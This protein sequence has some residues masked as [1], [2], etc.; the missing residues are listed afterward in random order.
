LQAEGLVLGDHDCNNFLE[1]CCDREV[2]LQ[3]CASLGGNVC[4]YDQTCSGSIT[5]ALDGACCIGGL[6]QTAGIEGCS[7]DGDCPTGEI[8]TDGECVSESGGGCSSDSDCASGQKC[9]NGSC[10]DESGNLWVWILL[11]AVL[12]ILVVIGIMFRDK[13]RIMFFKFGKG[14]KP[15]P[16]A[17]AP[18]AAVFGRRPTPRFIPTERPRTVVQRPS[19]PSKPSA[20]DKDIEDTF[21]KLKEMGK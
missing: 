9:D 20:K 8:C 6:C 11:L 12:I 2:P 15:K 5:E 14:G 21:K 7:Y 3:N 16:S 13:L 1:V 17:G 10:V 4:A 18:P 19:E